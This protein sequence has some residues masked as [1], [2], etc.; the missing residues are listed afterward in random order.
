MAEN[1]ITSAM[2]FLHAQ[3]ALHPGSGTALGAVDLPVQRERHTQWP[4]IPGSAVKGVLRDA[5][6]A[7]VG[8]PGAEADK[9][10][11]VVR[12]FGPPTAEADKHAGALAFTDCRILAFPV[13]SL[14]GVFAWATCPGL[15]QRL[16]RDAAM[17]GHPPAWAIPAVAENEA[18]CAGDELIVGD[19]KLVLEEF[20]FT[21]TQD[22]AEIAAWVA[23]H[24]VSDEPTQQRIKSHLVVLN[25]NDF[26]HF[27]RYAT[28]VAARIRLDYEAKTVAKGALFYQEFLPA[29]TIFYSVVIASASR[30]ADDTAT[31]GEV[32]ADLQA[33]V[34]PL[35]QFG[36]DETTG[37]GF[38]AVQFSA[39]GKE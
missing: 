39:N 27:V 35:L 30:K 20:E 23:Q 18:A 16:Q 10:D 7:N 14:R 1:S 28:E 4:T 32:L 3:T 31:A 34:P 29:E 21:K 22:A 5:Y 9:D 33:A 25:D 8:G 37:K 12:L 36:G 13:R 15:L 38:C 6:R 26:T 11:R 17:V 24:A 19:D 2:L